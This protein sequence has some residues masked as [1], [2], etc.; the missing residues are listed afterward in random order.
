MRIEKR[1]ATATLLFRGGN[2]RHNVGTLVM[3]VGLPNI[4]V[5]AYSRA[6]YKWSL[7]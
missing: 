3:P 2:T 4:S 1:T 5:R 7:I 6:E